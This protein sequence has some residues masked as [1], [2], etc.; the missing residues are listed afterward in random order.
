MNKTCKKC[1]GACC[2]HIIIPLGKM[3]Y[4]DTAWLRVRGTLNA[5][6]DWRV[7]SKCRHLGWFGRCRIYKKRPM[8]CRAYEVGGPDCRKARHEAV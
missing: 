4:I 1:G 6:G 2:K 5:A 8:N 7:E 3:Q